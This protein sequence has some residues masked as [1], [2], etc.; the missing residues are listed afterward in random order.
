[1]S[2]VSDD[3]G[4]DEAEL[5]LGLALGNK[6]TVKTQTRNTSS[7]SSSS[8]CSSTSSS[9]L[10]RAAAAVAADTAG[11]NHV[12]GWPPVRSYRISSMENRDK[13]ASSAEFGSIFGVYKSE[14]Q[15]INKNVAVEKECRIVSPYVKVTMDG[16]PIGRKV[17][18]SSFNS[19][20]ALAQTLEHMFVDFQQL[21]SVSVGSDREKNM[22]KETGRPASK[23]LMGSSEFVL[24]YEDK[25]GDWMLVGD[26]PWR[27]FRN[28]VKRLRIMRTF[29]AKIP[30]A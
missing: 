22:T 8:G 21:A 9:S 19:Y 17:D 25:E 10:G 1:M 28:S 20:E 7:F 24:T 29:D 5:Q 3:G 18:L 11:I 27:I 26:V 15:L 4:L 23:L 30:V 6:P 16:Y 14:C 13:F 2:T 12:V